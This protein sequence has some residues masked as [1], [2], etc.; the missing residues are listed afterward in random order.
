MTCASHKAKSRIALTAAVFFLTAAALL[1]AYVLYCMHAAQTPPSPESPAQ[2]E[3]APVDSDGF[4][5]VDWAYWQGINSD[6][7]GWLTIP[8]TD[9]N[10]PI[11]QARPASPDYYLHHDVYGNYNP[12]G[13]VYLDADC[14]EFGLSSRNAVIL[15][16]HFMGSTSIAPMGNIARYT[17]ET[18]AREHSRI[19]IQTPNVKLTYEARFTQIVNGLGRNKRT[20]FEGETDFR[21]WYDESRSSAALVLDGNTEPEQTVSLVTCSYNIWVNNERTVLVTS[22]WEPT[23]E[24][25]ENAQ[26]TAEAS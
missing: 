24:H 10:T 14:E 15:G 13:A 12:A 23:E 21:F 19:L 20:Y 3:S 17:D 22:T 8:G 5:E 2:E 11:L 16:H 7:I 26:I 9:V 6:V 25:T 1:C 18:F 4:P